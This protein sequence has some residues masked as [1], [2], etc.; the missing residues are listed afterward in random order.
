MYMYI[1]I[2]IYNMAGS[3]L[4]PLYQNLRLW[5]LSGPRWTPPTQVEGAARG[6]AEGVARGVRAVASFSSCSGNEAP[7]QLPPPGSGPQ[8]KLHERHQGRGRNIHSDAEIILESYR[9]ALFPESDFFR[10]AP[11]GYKAPRRPQD[12]SQRRLQDEVP[13]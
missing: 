3:I 11:G 9:A 13:E 10:V 12:S 5:L 8:C 1:Y 7:T 2:I 6:A 4:F